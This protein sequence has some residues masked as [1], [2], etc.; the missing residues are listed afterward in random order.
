VLILKKL[1]YDEEQKQFSKPKCGKC[2]YQMNEK[3]KKNLKIPPV[4]VIGGWFKV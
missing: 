3:V 4:D 2:S 1:L